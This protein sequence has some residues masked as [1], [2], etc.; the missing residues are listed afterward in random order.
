MQALGLS[1][2]LLHRQTWRKARIIFRGVLFRSQMLQAPVLKTDNLKSWWTS[3][4]QQGRGFSSFQ[5]IHGRRLHQWLLNAMMF[6]PLKIT[7]LY[8]AGSCQVCCGNY[9]CMLLLFL[10]SHLS[11][12]FWYSYEKS[13]LGC[14]ATGLALVLVR[15]S[16]PRSQ[17][18]W[19]KYKSL[20]IISGI[21]AEDDFGWRQRLYCRITNLTKNRL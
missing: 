9:Y 5:Q 10:L 20:N 16:I 19:L 2:L 12:S 18:S 1:G 8:T 21:K 15:S 6:L 4:Q 13:H 7:I 17:S 3:S 14:Y 11:L